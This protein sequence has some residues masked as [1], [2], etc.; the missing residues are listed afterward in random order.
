[1][2]VSDLAP[3][4]RSGPNTAEKDSLMPRFAANLTL[5][6]TEVPLLDR[7][8][9]ARDAG[10]DGVEMLFPYAAAIGDLK[11]ALETANLPLILINTP[12]PDWDT[13][14]R[15]CAAIPGAETR[16]R[17]GFEQALT[18]AEGLGTPIIHIMS[19]LASGSEAKQTLIDNLKWATGRVPEQ[20]LTI[21]PI[22][23]HDIPGYFLDDFDL[24]GDILDAVAAPNLALQFDAYHA[25]RITGDMPA[26][27]ARHGHRAT[28]IQIAGVPGRHEPAGGDIDYPAFFTHLDE[29]GYSGF[30]SAE[31]FPAAETTKGLAWLNS[32]R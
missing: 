8:A 13:G 6:F 30:V 15:G 20:P 14:G 10:F 1:M 11:S 23:T 24:A 16:F 27:W 3:I 31:Y 29:T 18:Y 7:I 5:L 4:R 25:H 2:S 19:G 32:A 26:T 12:V 21:E 17:E 22:N 9:A 28:H